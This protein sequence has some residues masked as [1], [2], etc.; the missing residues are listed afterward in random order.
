MTIAEFPKTNYFSSSVIICRESFNLTR[1]TG[2]KQDNMREKY[3][4]K[5]QTASSI[6]LNE[7]LMKYW[8]PNILVSTIFYIER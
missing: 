4:L 1:H 7:D 2:I 3:C 6:D 8:L 5:T